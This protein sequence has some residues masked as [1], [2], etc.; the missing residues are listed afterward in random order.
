MTEEFEWKLTEEVVEPGACALCGTCVA[1]CPGGIIE[2]TDEG[3]RLTEECA[4][5]GTGN[6]HTVCPRVDTAAYHLGLRI[7][8]RDYEPLTGGYRRAVGAVAA[9]S[10][11]RELG[12]DG[13]AVT[14]LARY[15]LE[16]GLA[17][18]VV[19]VTA[20]SAWKPC[21]TVVEDPEK[22]KDLAGSKYTRVGLV[23][24]LAEAADRGI[25]RVLAIGLPC[26]VNGLAKIQHFEIVAKGA[27]ALRNID[28]SPAEKLP[29]VVATI[30]LFCTKNFEYE[31]LVKLLREKGVDIED[32]ERFDITSG[33]L[34]VEIS[35]GETKEYDVKEFEEAIPEGCRICNDFTA[36][37]AD[38]SV[39]SVGTPEGVTTLLIRSETGE[40][41]V[42]GAVEAGYL[43]LR[44]AVNGSD[45]RRLAKL[46][47]DWA[48]KEAKNRLKEGRKV[49][50]FWVG[51]YGGVITRADGTFAVRLK[52]GPGGWVDDPDIF[53]AISGFLE[54]GYRAKFTDRQQLEIHGIPA[55]EIPEVV[56]R[57]RETGLNTG[58]EGPLVRTIMACPG[59]DNCSSGILNTEELARK[60]EEEL[61][62]EPTPYKFKIALSGCTNSCVRPQHHDLGFAG[63]VRP[64]VDPEKC[65]GCGQCVDACKVDAIR[66]IT[67]G[68][69]AAVA[70]TDYKRCVYCGK[71]INVCPEEAR[72]AEKE[73]IIVWIGGKGGREPV[74]GA[75]LDVFA[76]PDS[77]PTIA[78][79]VI[80]TYRELA[81]EPQKERLADT[82]RKHGLRQFTEAIRRVLS[83]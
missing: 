67:V 10:D 4:R 46:K 30:G 1:I 41:L 69:Q 56:E 48:M 54:E 8:G 72:Y 52:V 80:E 3:P 5:K 14:A 31:G 59:K 18:A 9:D 32:V 16:E 37:L 40:E 7:A 74:E 13:G 12:Q 82:I 78:H 73:G 49:P 81:E 22:V 53:R 50:P 26:Q 64:G 62:E 44:D 75:R 20:G 57:L 68:G 33:K 39:G 36:R 23:E 66:I 25:E 15:A 43:R 27:R 61:A 79:T 24:A 28:G 63:A 11:L 47:C 34:R 83:Q 76:D 70:D 19:G 71:C 77:I 21:V 17:D 45:V 65:T 58:S 6:C 51:D 35:G 2:L 29:E 38:V 60:L 55:T 42:E